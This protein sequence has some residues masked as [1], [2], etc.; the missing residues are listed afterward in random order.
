MKKGLIYGEEIIVHE[1]VFTVFCYGPYID[2][3]KFFLDIDN[4][5]LIL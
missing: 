3:S 5:V 1:N 2:G 4:L